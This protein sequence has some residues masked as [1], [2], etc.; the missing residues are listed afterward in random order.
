VGGFRDKEEFYSF[1]EAIAERLDA[2]DQQH[3]AERIRSAVASGST[4]GEILGNLGLELTELRASEVSAEAGVR[5]DVVVALD[6][7][8]D[9]LRS[10]GHEPPRPAA[11]N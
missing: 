4:S 5:A 11:R 7:I 8:D 10:V 2:A 1:I 9:A 3:W 6:V